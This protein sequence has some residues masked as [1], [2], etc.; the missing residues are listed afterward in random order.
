M[1]TSSSRTTATRLSRIR[2]CAVA[3]TLLGLTMSAQ[4]ALANKSPAPELQANPASSQVNAELAVCPGQTF[5][6]PFE[7][8]GDTNYY[9]LVEGS[10]FNQAGEGWELY[11]GAK[12]VET[13]RPDGTRGGVL[14]MPSGSFAISP[15]VCVTLQ[16][17]T[18]RTWVEAVEGNGSETIAIAYNINLSRLSLGSVSLGSLPAKAG[19]GWQLSK[20][21]QLNPQLG[22]RAEGVRDVR[23]VY[24]TTGRNTE[25]HISG[26]YVDPRFSN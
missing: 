23:F 16:Y 22:G 1:F 26:L 17:P 21:F 12:I 8:L 7:S 15:P 11:G 18:A 19:E 24:A 4:P 9:T 13:A 2:G 20:E 3:G 14:D 10:E 6:Q 25:F 5:S